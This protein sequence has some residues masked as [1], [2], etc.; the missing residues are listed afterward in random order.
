MNGSPFIGGLM[1]NVLPVK[2]TEWGGAKQFSLLMALWWQGV[3][4]ALCGRK[5]ASIIFKVP[6][7]VK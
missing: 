3:T 2:S 4:H 5:L 6:A 7:S 1:L